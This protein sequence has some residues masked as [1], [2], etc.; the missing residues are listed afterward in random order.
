ME[1]NLITSSN[2]SRGGRRGALKIVP[3]FLSPL[4]IMSGLSLQICQSFTFSYPLE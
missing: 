3:I 4:K 2:P 1:K